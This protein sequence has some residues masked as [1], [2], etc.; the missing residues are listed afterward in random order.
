MSS[1][2]EVRHDGS[3]SDQYP[4]IFKRLNGR[5]MEVSSTPQPTNS[6]ERVVAFASCPLRWRL[7]KQIGSHLIHILISP[8]K[9]RFP[10]QHGEPNNCG[11][12]HTSETLTTAANLVSRA[13]TRAAACHWKIEEHETD[14]SGERPRKQV[15]CFRASSYTAHDSLSSYIKHS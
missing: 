1:K 2:E 11:D 14:A 13:G 9:W 10:C 12:C 7:L 3:G 6:S 5:N 8:K 4:V 15:M